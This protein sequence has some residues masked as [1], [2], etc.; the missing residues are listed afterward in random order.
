ME[1]EEISK[2]QPAPAKSAENLGHVLLRD[3]DT[4]EIIL[5]PTP[6]KD[7]NDPLNWTRAYKIYVAGLSCYT[8]FL[9][10]FLSGGP[11]I[12]TVISAEAFFGP[13]PRLLEEHV[14]KAAYLF[15][16]SALTIG[17]GNL[18]W[19][20]LI[21]KYGRRTVYMVASTCYLATAIWSAVAQ[22]YTSELVARIFL[23]FSAGFADCLA[24]LT[25]SDLFF[26]HERGTMM[27]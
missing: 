20:P 2:A 10:L 4:K 19:M 1:D 23:G 15:T 27:V 22:T 12:T 25:I 13:D 3:P 7:P 17:V 6:S 5:V 16:T 9:T 24:P 26:L 11:A 8:V 14:A 21:L 18:F